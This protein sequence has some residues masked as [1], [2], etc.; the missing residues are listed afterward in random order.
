[1]LES[2]GFLHIQ[3]SHCGLGSVARELRIGGTQDCVMSCEFPLVEASLVIWTDS[4]L[5]CRI[6]L[7]LF[8][9]LTS[10]FLFLYKILL[11]PSWQQGLGLLMFFTF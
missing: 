7:V 2:C 1:M 6:T 11:L 9:F 4:S 8:T 10:L 3:T 5:V